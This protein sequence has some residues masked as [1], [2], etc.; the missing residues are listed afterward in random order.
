M[1]FTAAEK[2]DIRRFCGFGLYGGG[3]PLPASGY[4]FSTRYGI[5][6]YKLNTLGA[7]EEAVV[8]TTYLANLAIMEAAV[9]GTG[10]NLDTAQAAVW[11][12]N[13]YEY[14]DRKVLFDGVR[15]DLCDFL[16]VPA[17]P[18][19]SSSGGSVALVV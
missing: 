15:R 9:F 13:K 11:T 16:G 4:R 5:L 10:A 17:G 19:L 2:V 12:H 7:E 18:S 3:Q 8:R 6:E 14:R 1:A